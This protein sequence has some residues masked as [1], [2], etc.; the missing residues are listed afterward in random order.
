[1][2]RRN[3]SDWNIG[4]DLS[5][6]LRQS[7]VKYAEM[8]DCE[9][10]ARAQRGENSAAE[11]M[12]YK[13]RNLVRTKV[14][15]YFL[16]GAEK[17]DLLQVGQIGLWQAIIDFRAD[18]AISFPAFA[19]VCIT[20]HIITAIKT[21]T[22]QKQ[23]PLNQSLSLESPSVDSTTD[24]NL[25]DII[26]NTEGAD[27]EDLVLRNE[28]TKIL[29]ETLQQVLSEFEWHVLSGYQVGK[30]YREIASELRCKTKSVDNALA[31]IKRKVSGVPIGNA[32]L[33]ELL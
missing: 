11:Y 23:M 19:K 21:A 9:I 10:V 12:L 32:D 15:S 8:G 18:K 7:Q 28:D 20:R 2:I 27:P 31:R 16:V 29:H 6:R 14:K 25:S 13:Y 5:D 1:M 26:P 30:S 22:R 17:E 4:T 24:W 33:S 3:P